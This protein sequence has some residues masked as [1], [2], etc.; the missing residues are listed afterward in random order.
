[1]EGLQDCFD[2]SQD[3]IA[4]FGK[5]SRSPPGIDIMGGPVVEIMQ[6]AES[7]SHGDR[8]TQPCGS[9]GC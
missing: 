3:P 6:Q 5:R 4:I 2:R 1:A 7:T 9:E 8:V